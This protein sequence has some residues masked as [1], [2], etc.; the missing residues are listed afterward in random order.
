MEERWWRLLRLRFLRERAACLGESKL[1]EAIRG[2]NTTRSTACCWTKTSR[3]LSANWKGFS[4]ARGPACAANSEGADDEVDVRGGDVFSD[5]GETSGDAPEEDD[6][7]WMLSTLEL[8]AVVGAEE[9]CGASSE[10]DG[11]GGAMAAVGA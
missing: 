1:G 7:A 11:D 8:V 4:V 9:E 2:C 6:A 10:G 5:E 3:S